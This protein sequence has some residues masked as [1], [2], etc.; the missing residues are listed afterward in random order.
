MTAPP[1]PHQPLSDLAFEVRGWTRL[2]ARSASVADVYLDRD[3]DDFGHLLNHR[4]T[5]DGHSGFICRGVERFAHM[6]PWR[7][8]ELV[9]LLILDS[10]DPRRDANGLGT[11]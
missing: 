1:P 11:T 8:G 7:R 4:V 6:P 10:E 3:T 5:L 9:G 2:S